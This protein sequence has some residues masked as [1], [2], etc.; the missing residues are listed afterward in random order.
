MERQAD[1]VAGHAA[2]RLRG[3]HRVLIVDDDPDVRTLLQTLLEPEGFVVDTAGSG[4]DMRARMSVAAPDLVL[5]DLGLPDQ[6]GFS[7]ARELRQ[8][9]DVA[10]IIVTGKNDEA[11]QVVGFEL[12]ADDYVVKPF[13]PRELLA[14]IKSVLRR[15][16]PAATRDAPD[17][18]GARLNPRMASLAFPGWTLDLGA[19]ELRKDDGDR[20]HLTSVEFELLAAL[21]QAPNQVLS[22][23]HLLEKS[24]GRQWRRA[25]RSIDIHIGRLRSKI[26]PDPNK[27]TLI[28]TIRGAGYV[29]A[30]VVERTDAG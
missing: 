18:P 19:R 20:V 13:R 22:R 30:A 10:L 21:A 9:S 27:P 24:V 25:D 2:D 29:F 23:H 8:T 26:E 1:T 11:D 5:L 15:V 6:D 28:K 7:L 3:K 17:A 16:A 14:R 4:G 12:G